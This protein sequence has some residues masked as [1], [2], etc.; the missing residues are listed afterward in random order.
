MEPQV[1]HGHYLNPVL[2][3]YIITSAK[4]KSLYEHA[5]SPLELPQQLTEKKFPMDQ[6]RYIKIL[7]RFRGVG[8]QKT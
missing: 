4:Y 7:T 2:F 6:F 5:K 3:A 1:A 8:E